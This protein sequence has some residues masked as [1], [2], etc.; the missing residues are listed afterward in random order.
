MLSMLEPLQYR[1]RR[2]QGLVQRGL[3]SLRSRGMAATWRRVLLELRRPPAP[4]RSALFF[5]DPDR[6]LHEVPKAAAPAVSIVI[7]VHGQIARTLTCLRALAEH[8]PLAGIEV[9]VVDDAS[10][11][12]T[13]SRLR[14]IAGLRLVERARNGGFIAACNDGAA[15]AEA[16]T[17]VFLN[18]DT[19]AQPGWL[20]AL[21]DTFTTHPDA[22]IVGAQLLYPDGRLQEAGGI[23]HADGSAANRGR[24]EPADAPP[25]NHVCD[26]DYVSGA[27]LAIP[28]A[29]FRQLGGFDA[30]YAPAYYEDTD[31]AFAARAAGYR[32]LYQPAAR[33]IHDEGGTA[34][35]DI[36]H[37]T[38]A[39]QVRN[40]EV[41]AA[42]WADALARRPVAGTHPHARELLLIDTSTPR[43]DRDSASVR[44]RHLIALWQAQGWRI[45]LLPLDLA[46]A[47][48]S[49]T[50]LEQAGVECW[51][52][53]FV[54]DPARWL[55]RHGHRFDIAWVCRHHNMS[56]M[57]PV[58]RRHAPRARVVFDT[59]DLHGLREQRGAS[60][61]DDRMAERRAARTHQLELDLMRRVDLSVVVSEVER[62]L[63]QRSLPDVP[64]AVVSNIHQ[65]VAAP[66]PLAGRADVLFV[67]GFAHP[68]NADAVQWFVREVWPSVH[69][70]HPQARFHCVG[71]D[72]PS[73]V[74]DLATLPGVLV[75]GHV[76]DLD[77]L[78]DRCRLSVAP[79]RFG[80]GVKGK[81][82]H[83]MAR[84]VPVV[85]T[86]CAAEGMHLQHGQD[87]L[88]GDSAGA[89]ATEVVRLLDDDALW[90]RLSAGGL[91][92]VAR[93]FSVDVARDQLRALW[94]RLDAPQG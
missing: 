27:A 62:D 38:K 81:I 15:V 66:P 69:A 20:D 19:I 13:A 76:P 36:T 83:S 9:I 32:V 59:I 41:F 87:A 53:P 47:G 28:T 75:H 67:G 89:F 61:H 72:P 77:A 8:P 45:T 93:H 54:R 10:P 26:A 68:P 16:G 14:G 40:R 63:L 80:A 65:P 74:T 64:V 4:A 7:P 56:A 60:I 35:T 73:A 57:L 5:P 84:G 24:F 91:R 22:G 43:P 33:V 31:L 49:T 92:N 86:H 78:L 39:Y 52:A 90:H 17:L 82:N 37:G 88:L 58:L 12:D 18:N 29:L 79:L 1:L 23:V 2:L 85:A 44:L 34:G 25:Y 51:H 46:H 70:R 30:R 71:A 42:K 48:T 21:L 11:D 50:A 55:H 3:T 94:Q 6:P